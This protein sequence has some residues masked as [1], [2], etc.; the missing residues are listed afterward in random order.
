MA[1]L[2]FGDQ[3]SYALGDA[4]WLYGSARDG[5]AH[6]TSINDGTTKYG[7]RRLKKGTYSVV[8][9]C[10]LGIIN[11]TL[12]SMRPA[13]AKE[14]AADKQKVADERAQYIANSKEADAMMA[15]VAADPN[16]LTLDPNADMDE[17][18]K[19]MMGGGMDEFEGA[20]RMDALSRA[21]GM[22]GYAGA[23]K[24]S[25]VPGEKVRYIGGSGKHPNVVPPGTTGI[26]QDDGGLMACFP[27]SSGQPKGI[28]VVWANKQTFLV[29]V[30]EV[31]PVP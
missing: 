1:K 20:R 3:K 29:Y 23:K 10:G 30:T 14:D 19:F 17:C 24:V 31:E 15:R 8:H 13:T 28:K 21:V 16:P 22:G 18:I 4:V 6:V 11:V 9:N 5:V 12:D 25:Y 2:K 27:V 26:V 7:G